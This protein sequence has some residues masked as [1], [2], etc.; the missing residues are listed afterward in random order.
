MEAAKISIIIPVYNSRNYL[1]AAV[2][3]L[4]DQD[5]ENK[6]IVLIDDGS[7]DGSSQ[8]CDTLAE[9][10]PCVTSY[11]KPNGGICSARNYGLDKATGELVAFMDNDDICLPGFLSD[12][13]TLVEQHQAD[14]VRFG[15]TARTYSTKGKLIAETTLTP[16]C[17]AFL[18]GAEIFASYD[19]VRS[20]GN[21]VWTGMYRKE[22]LDANHLRF[23][24]TLKHGYEDAL[25]VLNAFE[26]ARTVVVNPH[27]YYL[28]IRRNSHSTSLKKSD[29]NHFD[30][31]LKAVDA[32]MTLMEEHDVETLLPEFYSKR[33]M[34]WVYE[35]FSLSCRWHSGFNRRETAKSLAQVREAFEPLLTDNV[36]T[37]LSSVDNFLLK[38]LLSKRYTLLFFALRSAYGIGTPK[39]ALMY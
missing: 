2:T 11:H 12:N 5:Y 29:D 35:G 19:I 36:R 21:G 6:E 30:S 13:A 14:C 8:L 38:L 22:F 18:S 20:T 23:D 26:H 32:E 34:E 16:C 9:Q 25:F 10:H 31:L 17:E 28:W 4:L 27:I 15:R 39:M 1:E 24:E 37:R 7:S 3:S 33:I